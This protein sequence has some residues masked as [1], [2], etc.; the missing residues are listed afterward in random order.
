LALELEYARTFKG[1]MIAERSLDG[2][3]ARSAPVRRARPR[4][5]LEAM[6]AACSRTWPPATAS[7]ACT[8][9]TARALLHN[10]RLRGEMR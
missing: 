7:P 4:D 8:G 5:W 1:P 10:G 6:Q 2:D 9:P 3:A